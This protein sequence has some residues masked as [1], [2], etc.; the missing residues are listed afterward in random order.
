SVQAAGHLEVVDGF[1]RLERWRGQGAQVVP[2]VI[3]G[4]VEPYGAKRLLLIANAPPRTLS[5]MDEARVMASLRHDD[6]LGPKS[7]AG[8]LGRKPHWVAQRLAMA[9][10]LSP[11]VERR[12]DAGRVGPALASALVGLGSGDQEAVLAAV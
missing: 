6:G 8:L 10:G 2:V 3:E 4:S 11:A 5:V 9:A 1:K 12:I 7:I